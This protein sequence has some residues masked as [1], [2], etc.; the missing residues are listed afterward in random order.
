MRHPQVVLAVLCPLLVPGIAPGETDRNPA[1]ASVSASAPTPRRR[2]RILRNEAARVIDRLILTYGETD[3]SPLVAHLRGSAGASPNDVVPFISL[4]HAHLNRFERGNGEDDLL[5]AL[6]VFEIPV[7]AEIWPA[8]GER[9][10][11]SITLSHLM[12]GLLRLRRLSP[13]DAVLASR[14]DVLWDRVA[15]L[16]ADEADRKLTDDTPYQPYISATT[17]DTKA[18][19]NAWEA[20]FLAWASG[21]YP[22]HPRAAAWEEK[23]RLL[24]SL[25]VVRES[26]AEFFEGMQIATVRED[27][28]LGNHGLSPNPYYAVATVMLLRMGA[29]AYRMTGRPVPG[30]FDRNVKGLHRAYRTYCSRDESGRWVWNLPSDPVGDPALWPLPGLDET[31]FVLS[32]IAQKLGEEALWLPT[33]PV[34]TLVP[35]EERG[36]RPDA[37]LGRAIQNAK[38]AWY[39]LDGAYLW[40]E[41]GAPPGPD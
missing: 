7:G 25:A 29:L 21:L 32:L 20:V 17:G 10:A 4:G 34:E 24:A 3:F 41:Q 12:K 35:D 13:D 6:D 15:Q 2:D 14:I 26:D 1:P 28:T 27:F 37:V 30:E 11:S 23:G 19:E 18:E 5:R 22:E 39:Y 9:W 38:V 40:L 8:W 36:L 33:S 16:A 31:D